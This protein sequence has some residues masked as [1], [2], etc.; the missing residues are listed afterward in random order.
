MAEVLGV[1][2][3]IAGLFSLTVQLTEVATKYKDNVGSVEDGIEAFIQELTG[4]RQV[5]EKLKSA[6][7]GRKL[8]PKFDLSALAAIETACEKNLKLLLDKLTRAAAWLQRYFKNKSPFQLSFDSIEL[9]GAIC[10]KSNFSFRG[11]I[12]RLKWPFEVERTREIANT[13][14]RYFTIF[15]WMLHYHERQAR[16]DPRK[17]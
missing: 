13:L 15:S 2:A 9:I 11:T 16:T 3:G 12:F 10:R 6:W 5:L 1:A 4:L 8:P 17:L 7:R 14:H